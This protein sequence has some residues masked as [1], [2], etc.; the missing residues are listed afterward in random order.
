[1]ILRSNSAVSAA[2][3]ALAIPLG[4]CGA[5]LH[6]PPADSAALSQCRSA[7]DADG[8]PAGTPTWTRAD[9]RDRMA[10]DRWCEAVGPAVLD[11]SPLRAVTTPHASRSLAVVSW[12]VHVGG[13]DVAALVSSLRR[14]Q[15]TGGEPVDDFV[16]LLQEAYRG[17]PRVPG[18][19]IGQHGASRIHASPQTGERRDIV[20]MAR[21]QG[22]ALYYVP[23]MRNGVA[24]DGAAEDRG[25]A[26]LS[27]LPLSDFEAI[28]LPFEQQRRVAIA[29]TVDGA[30]PGGRLRVVSAHFNA[31]A[32][33]R[34][35][36]VFTSGLRATQ[37][38]R[39]TAALADDGPAVVGSDLNT[40]VDGRREPA[41]TWLQQ[42]FPDTPA[43]SDQPTFAF[44]FRLDYLFF[45]LP[46]GW[47]GA[48]RRLDDRFGSDHHP[49]FG[50][51]HASGV[52]SPEKE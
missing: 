28:E 9:D 24:D 22:L 13:A 47:R 23:S 45:R 36:W 40:W 43:L 11:S 17:G 2:V 50:W 48:S 25:N 31:S 46:A 29:A 51:V 19:A 27:T 10:L 30:G 18:H 52:I 3:L 38:R 33:A 8:R 20:S 16:L 39:L 7:V 37:A 21:E 34:R 4:A 12:N 5:A 1:M 26:I 49:L 14:G 41:V 42:A 6:L 15:F 35:L 44:G 32:G